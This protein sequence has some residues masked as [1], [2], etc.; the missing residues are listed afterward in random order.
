MENS[1][2]RGSQQPNVLLPQLLP[3]YIAPPPLASPQLEQ[4]ACNSAAPLGPAAQSCPPPEVVDWSSLLLPSTQGLQVRSTLQQ[5]MAAGS[6]AA[7]AGAVEGG[8]A[9][10]TAGSNSG[11]ACG[12]GSSTSDGGGC[13][14]KEMKGKRLGGG[15]GK[16]KASRPRFAFET[17]SENDILDDGYRWRKYGQK[18]VK[19]SACPRSYYR[20][21]H[22]TC[23]V[24]KQVQRL[25]KDRSI[26]VTTYE[27]VH[28]HPCEK[29]MEA[30]TPI[31]KQLQFLSQ[32]Q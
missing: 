15:R 27:G 2:Q 9:V 20:C 28:N 14:N 5:A 13:A 22:H 6:A 31:L 4:Q 30:L 19:N 11:G 12:T 29:L 10:V 17:R 26:V 23:N 1:L 18:A 3:T 16:K 25:A 8:G 21:T 7:G 24:K 32:F